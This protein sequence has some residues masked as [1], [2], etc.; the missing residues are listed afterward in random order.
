M[1]HLWRWKAFTILGRSP[2]MALAGLPGDPFLLYP[3]ATSPEWLSFQLG[4]PLGTSPGDALRSL[5]NLS[6]QIE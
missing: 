3:A 4:G 1:N 5:C 6:T 2:L